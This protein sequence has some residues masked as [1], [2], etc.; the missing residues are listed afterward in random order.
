MNTFQSSISHL[1]LCFVP[2]LLSWGGFASEGTHGH[3]QERFWLSHVGGSKG[4]QTGTDVLLTSSEWRP[5]R[6]ITIP[7]WIT[8]SP[9]TKNDPDQNV[10]HSLVG[11]PYTKK[12]IRW[13]CKN[14]YTS[15]ITRTTVYNSIHSTK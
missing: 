11:K 9:T 14:E 1:G 2:V 8:K 5:G 3:A 6:Q 7:Q 12:I 4:V 10:H 15:L 13:A